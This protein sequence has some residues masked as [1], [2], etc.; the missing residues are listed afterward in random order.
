[1]QTVNYLIG[2]R[3]K[4]DFGTIITIAVI[5]GTQVASTTALSMLYRQIVKRLD[6]SNGRISKLEDRQLEHI[7]HFHS[8]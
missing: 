5:V 1:M 8:K 4:L 3:M 6:V 2:L 7:E